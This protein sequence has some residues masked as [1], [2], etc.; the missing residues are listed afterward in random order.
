V[1]LVAG[2]RSRSSFARGAALGLAVGAG[3]LV[4]V[5]GAASLR[6][7]GSFAIIPTAAEQVAPYVQVGSARSAQGIY[8]V[9]VRERRASVL[10]SWIGPYDAGAAFVPVREVVPPGSSE[11]DQQVADQ[12]DMNDSQRI[13]AAVAERALG[14]PVRVAK[15]GARIVDVSHGSPADRAGLHAADV[16]TAV[17]GT[18]VTSLTELATAMRRV[19][20]G[21]TVTL[22]IARGGA[23][24][25]V[26]VGTT[27]GQPDGRAVMGV[28]VSDDVEI[29]LP[30]P[31]KYTLENVVGPSAGLAFALQIYA[32]LGGL[33]GLASHRVVVSGALDADGNVHEVGA[34]KQKAYGAALVHAEAYVVPAG[35]AAEAESAHR[36]GLRVIGV[37]T[38]AQAVAALQRILR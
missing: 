9:A 6:D 27:R 35:N 11:Q 15:G 30:V 29:S 5:A 21:T 38:F 12:A 17:N 4:L 23:P 13:A 14:K 22:A 2:T 3:A 36:R 31:V 10:E 37:K 1:R 8:F 16:I 18:R 24:R 34:V 20:A 25:S 19:P 28:E 33:P 32:T 7:S 26:R